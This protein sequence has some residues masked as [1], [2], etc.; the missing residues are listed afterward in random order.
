MTK[1]TSRYRFISNAEI[2]IFDSPSTID[3]DH[4][5]YFF[6]N[7]KKQFK[8]ELNKLGYV[9]QR[10]YFLSQN[11][12]FN[13][14]KFI[15][16]DVKY[17]C[18]LLKID[19]TKINKHI[20]WYT[21]SVSR[22]HKKEILEEF[23]YH[24][25]EIFYAVVYD[26]SSQL[27]K[28]AIRPKIIFFTLVDFL[29]ENKIEI[30]S[31]S[32]LS[33]LVMSSFNEYEK[34]IINQVNILLTQDQKLL[35]DEF[36]QMAAGEGEL[37]PQ[38]P[39]LITTLKAP[40]QNT[41][42]S[43]NK[44]SVYQF[45]IISSLF[46]EFESVLQDLTIS[47][48][49]VNYYAGWV[50]IAEQ[51][52]FNAIKN[53]E[54][55]YLY[56]LAFLTYQYRIRQDLF[57]DTFLKSV[58]TFLNQT[59]NKVKDDFI[60]K[61]GTPAKHVNEAKGRIINNLDKHESKLDKV[62][63][64]LN[65]DKFSSEEK[66]RASLEI[67]NS[68]ASLRDQIIKE[69]D[70]LEESISDK[71]KDEMYFEK[72]GSG[73]LKLSRKL[74][75]ILL[76]VNFNEKASEPVIY[77]P[78]FDYQRTNGNIISD[79]KTDFISSNQLK[80]IKRDG[81]FDKKLYKVLLYI[82]CA[83]NIKSGALNLKHSNNYRSINDYMIDENEWQLNKNTLLESSNLSH[84]SDCEGVLKAL[85]NKLRAQY[86]NTNE[87]IN[88]N[89]DLKFN[90]KGKPIINTP[91]NET[92]NDGQLVRLISE[93]KIIPLIDI[94]NDISQSTN[95]LKSFVHFSMKRGSNV[96]PNK[97]ILIASIVALGC[98]IGVRKM[99]KITKGVGPEKLE[100]TVRWYFSIENIQEANRQV[101]EVIDKLSLPKYFKQF[102]DSHHTSSDGQKFGVS[103]PSI[104]SSYS[105]KYFGAGKGVSAYG[106]IDEFSRTFY[107][108]VISSSE[109]E[110]A[111][112]LDGLLH[113]DVVESTI[114]STDTH[115]Y[116]EV[117]FGLCNCLKIKF[118]PRI[119]RPGA[120]QI[121][122]FKEDPVKKYKEL[123]YKIIP[124]DRSKYIDE[125]LIIDQWDNILRLL[126]SIRTK[127]VTASILLKRLSS[128]AKNHP[129]NRALK[130]LGRIHKSIFLLE[131]YDDRDLR[132]RIEKQ[133]NKGELWHKF[134]KEIFFGNNQEFKVGSKEEQ[135][136]AVSC[137][138]L[139]QNSVVLWN[140]LTLTK[141][142]SIVNTKTQNEIIHSLN[143][144]NLITWQHVNIHGEYDFDLLGTQTEKF[145]LNSL[146]DFQLKEF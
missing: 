51:P 139:I 144:T 48:A 52:Q 106:F 2:R 111:Y 7:S 85:K 94:L 28:K 60:N 63:K 23:G 83:N 11:K 122:T 127:E 129:L 9:L 87:K 6:E 13:P 8:S 33:T 146:I 116:T 62:R 17:C 53:P 77:N 20:N 61:R 75:D 91:K 125:Q 22:L 78:I 70:S 115:G 34:S 50:I 49:L 29:I 93:N 118:A 10:G 110:A 16:S 86:K 117:I 73:S 119:K 113:N 98:N 15:K 88:S 128:Y 1:T 84:L 19:I 3:V 90:N 30:P 18:D 141:S 38:N 89:E 40:N 45:K 142:L 133:L 105:Y 35:L 65:S 39:Y 26:Q 96:S 145:D 112:I 59:E 55:R 124:P 103:V 92:E 123:G 130:E 24:S 31:Y 69:F 72:L 4:R 46:H 44:E 66:I 54:K 12:F 100:N 68:N 74:K 79:P 138:N 14:K 80:F 5:T 56:V 121:Y 36:L 140:Y 76:S 41:S 27:V 81:Q 104:H 134:A 21:E 37:S 95:C 135:R 97:E 114:H 108:T 143:S 126:V 131:Y 67:I 64:I 120:Q 132:Q 43:K 42:A 57:I 109:R 25:F 107:D 71:L 101:I 136:L 58:Q 99:G 32:R 47:E 82:E 137:R 102:A